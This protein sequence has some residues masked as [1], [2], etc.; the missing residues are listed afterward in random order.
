MTI[1]EHIRARVL[2]LL[3]LVKYDKAPDADRLTFINDSE[4]VAKMKLREYNVWYDGDGDELLNFYT[5]NNV[6]DFNYEPFYMRNKKNYFWAI[7]STEAQIKRT[8]SGR[9]RRLC[10]HEREDYRVHIQG[11][12][13][14][15][16]EAVHAC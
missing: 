14:D 6:I 5:K 3:G 12:L 10:V 11:L 13:Y 9:E 2:K 16:Q 1:F 8:H 7:S 15:G 4:Q